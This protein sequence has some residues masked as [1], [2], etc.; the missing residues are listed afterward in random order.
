MAATRSLRTTIAA[1]TSN[2]AGSTTTGT[3]IDLTAKY[4][5][6]LTAKIANGATGPTVAASVKVYT[7]GDNSA[8]KLFTTLT[9]DNAN[10]AVS[11]FAVEIPPSVMYVRADVTGNTAQAVTCEA[12]LQELTTV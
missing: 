11:E 10:S 12:L 7:S 4:G 2:T 8:F 3:V 1:G 5:G 9:A 6:L